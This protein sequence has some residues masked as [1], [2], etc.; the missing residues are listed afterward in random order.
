MSKAM[1][2]PLVLFLIAIPLVSAAPVIENTTV[3]PSDDL[4]LGEDATISLN[5]F[6]SENKTIEE[7]YADITGPDITIPRKSFTKSGSKYTLSVSK[8]YLDR[9]GQFDATI[10]CRNNESVFNT[11][12]KSFTVSEL[13]GYINA[14]SPNPAYFGDTIEIDFI[15]KRGDTKISSGVAFNVSFNDQLKNLKIDP[16]YDINKGWILKIDSPTISDIYDVKVTAF[17]DRTNAT[18]YISVDVRN[19]IE[20]SIVSVDKSWIKSS[21]NITVTLKALEKGGLIGL[22]KD[23]V[24]IKIN[25]IDAEITAVSQH[26]SLFDVKFI[27]P[28]ISSGKY[29]LEAYLNHKSS[30]YSDSEPIDYIVSIE[31]KVLD[32]DNKVI[33][34][35]I[36]FI[37][38]G[39][40]KLSLVTDSYGHYTG[41]LPPGVYDLE[42]TFPNSVIYLSGAS[43]SSFD[44]PIKHFYSEE[45]IV[46]GI[47]NGGLHDYEIDLS[48]SRAEIEMRYTEKNIINE[49]NLRVFRCSNWNSGRKVCN[50]NW[51]EVIGETDIVRNRVKVTSST[52]SAFV[53]GETK[54]IA[55]DFSLDKGIYYLGDKVNV[56]GIV[57][58]SD[59]SVVSNASISAYIKN[60]KKDYNVV[61]D[62]NG[63]FSIEIPSPKEEGGYSLVLKAKKHPYKDFSGEEKFEIVKSR[64]IFID[65]P[66]TIKIARGENYSQVF[67]ILNNGQADIKNIKISL[68]GLPESY[69]NIVSSNIDLKSDEKKTL[70]IDFFVPVYAEPGI[71]SATLKIENGGIVEEKVFGFN[72]FEESESEALPTGLATGFALPQINYL[73][74][75]YIAIFAV[76]C[77]SVAVI[78][79]KRKVRK[80]GGTHSGSFLLDVGN[81]LRSSKPRINKPDSKN[82]GSYD[83]LIIT[84]FPNVMEFSKELRKNKGDK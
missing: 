84:E 39:V 58:D 53:I 44:D 14:I 83:K 4:W 70:Y 48:Y 78:L 82:I 28:S 66:E 42:I 71:S 29:Q 17:Y 36:K 13:T 40:E 8:E 51:L 15:F 31:G 43:I 81:Y 37:Q 11:T 12:V 22:N 6:E 9:T 69:Y 59:G 23:N 72:I 1:L 30:S 79:K 25:S 73:D 27:A 61:A 35:Q 26:D 63:V 49:N 18:D 16:A 64:S 74:L 52:L 20:F 3:A 32:R 60:T 62:E 41:S 75:V 77:F 56:R 33:N 24:D 38:S 57:K 55:V 54:D 19:S 68:E 7:V 21:D 50:D 45:N 67:D 34:V 47:R 65:F 5:C 80:V 46:P 76:V 10:T 2:L